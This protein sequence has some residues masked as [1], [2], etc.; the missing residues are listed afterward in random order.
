MENI[1]FNDPMGKGPQSRIRW[2]SADAEAAADGRSPY[3]RAQDNDSD[4]LSIRSLRSRR[5]SVDPGT[6]LPIQYRTVSFNIDESK[7]ENLAEVKRAKDTTA[8]GEPASRP[9]GYF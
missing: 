3:T 4:A 5:N 9:A 1:E 7:E 8:K 2:Q 6:A